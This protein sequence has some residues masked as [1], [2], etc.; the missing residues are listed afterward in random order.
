MPN[1]PDLLHAPRK[2]PL[3]PE[4]TYTRSLQP[5][6]TRVTQRPSAGCP[7]T[8]NM[9]S[10]REPVHLPSTRTLSTV[11]VPAKE[12]YLRETA[13]SQHDKRVKS[14][15]SCTGT[16]GF[17]AL[18]S[19]ALHRYRTFDTLK[20]CGCPALS[21]SIG[22]VFSTAFATLCLCVTFW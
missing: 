2:S 19:T 8:L 4:V 10:L 18:H 13:S 14:S 16:P 3:P 6:R 12:P 5:V 15:G 20:V 17:L 21:K 11:P 22:A 1:T 7:G 9:K